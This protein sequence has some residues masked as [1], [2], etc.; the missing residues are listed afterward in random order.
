M[1]AFGM[2]EAMLSHAMPTKSASGQGVTAGED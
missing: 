1:L 2:A